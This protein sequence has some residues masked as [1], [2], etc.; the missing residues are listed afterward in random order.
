MVVVHICP[1]TAA[2]NSP[3]AGSTYSEA[4]HPNRPP[5]AA[6]RA[7]SRRAVLRAQSTSTHDPPASRQSSALFPPFLSLSAASSVSLSISPSA[8]RKSIQGAPASRTRSTEYGDAIPRTPPPRPPPRP[9]TNTQTHTFVF[10]FVFEFIRDPS[11]GRASETGEGCAPID[12][13]EASWPGPW[14]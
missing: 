13:H 4:S 3:A 14:A 7:H 2:G 8:V 6:P 1:G 9:H 12:A 10:F 11:W 5:L